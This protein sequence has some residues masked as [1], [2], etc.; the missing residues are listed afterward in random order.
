MK[1]LLFATANPHKI[2]EASG[3][4][5]PEFKLI[6]PAS[7]G[8]SDDV[9]ETGNSLRANSLQKARYIWE[10]SG[11]RDCFADDTGLEVD[12]LGG[13]PGVFTARYAGEPANPQA[14]MEKLLEEMKRREYGASA[15]R[16]FGIDTPMAS[17]RARFRTC[18][19]LILNDKPY[20]FDGILEGQIARSQSG[21]R[22]FGYDPV[23]IPDDYP[24]RTLAQ[25]SPEQKNAIS[26]RG[27]ALREMAAFLKKNL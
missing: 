13:A 9:P 19:T 4:L 22:G 15:A 24:D 7:I 3:I 14:N 10:H 16:R 26:H 11:G 27:K 1:E 12:I 21:A 23:F 25:L 20:F 6:S 17:R 2:E 8:I 18:V 5:G